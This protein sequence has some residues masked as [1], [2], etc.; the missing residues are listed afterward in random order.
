MSTSAISKPYGLVPYAGNIIQQFLD[1][2]LSIREIGVTILGQPYV[3]GVEGSEKEI[4][5]SEEKIHS[6]ISATDIK[7]QDIKQYYITKIENLFR[8]FVSAVRSQGS[9]VAFCCKVTIV[10]S[11]DSWDEFQQTLGQS[12]YRYGHQETMDRLFQN[13]P[14]KRKTENLEGKENVPISRLEQMLFS[15]ESP[16]HHHYNAFDSIN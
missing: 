6:N 4:Y 14:P 8:Q 1:E 12:P 16:C 11:T 13:G 2:D 9:H 10:A 15:E 3:Q 7:D 5:K